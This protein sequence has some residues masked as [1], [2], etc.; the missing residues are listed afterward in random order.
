[1]EV[2]YFAALALKKWWELRKKNV[3]YL[4]QARCQAQ[5]WNKLK[6]TIAI[7]HIQCEL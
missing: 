6:Y 5:V 3:N 1:M 2:D 7:S 4:G